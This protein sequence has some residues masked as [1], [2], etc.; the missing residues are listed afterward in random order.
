MSGG[1]NT[2]ISHPIRDDSFDASKV[3]NYMRCRQTL[4]LARSVAG[5]S[6]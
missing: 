4:V 3:T 5:V 6:T 1:A 2:K